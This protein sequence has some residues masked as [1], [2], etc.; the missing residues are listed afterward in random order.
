MTFDARVRTVEAIDA[1]V[2]VDAYID[3]VSNVVLSPPTHDS[4]YPRALKHSKVILLLRRRRSH[5]HPLR[6]F[7]DATLPHEERQNRSHH[8]PP[9]RRTRDGTRRHTTRGRLDRFA[10]EFRT[11][12]AS[13]LGEFASFVVRTAANAWRGAVLRASIVLTG[14]DECTWEL[15]RTCMV[16]SIWLTMS[17]MIVAPT[18]RRYGSM[19]NREAQGRHQQQHRC[20][21]PHRETRHDCDT[22]KTDATAE[23]ANRYLCGRRRV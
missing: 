8:N 5:R 13:L 2:C 1:M 16:F 3:T 21:R 23:V 4:K 10:D 17:I 20:R 7:L 12:G 6:P 22:A 9:Q 19:H 11:V 14:E 18:C 15:P